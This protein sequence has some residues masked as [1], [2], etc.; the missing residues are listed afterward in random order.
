VPPAQQERLLWD[1]DKERHG[2]QL[3][4]MALRRRRAGP[5][6]VKAAI[7][8][9][10]MAQPAPDWAQ[11]L[12]LYTVLLSLEDTP[13]VRVNHAIALAETGLVHAALDALEKLHTELA[14]FQPFQAAFAAVLKKAGAHDKAQLAYAKAIALAEQESDRLF[15]LAQM[16]GL[17]A[18]GQA[19]P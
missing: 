16:N 7:S 17:R 4:D 11:I 8:A 9:C 3:L 1:T 14:Q 19:K 15:L 5:F 13:V 10:Q 12:Q 2:R 6:Q 18:N